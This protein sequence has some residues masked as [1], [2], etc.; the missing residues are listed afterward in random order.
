MISQPCGL[1]ILQVGVQIPVCRPGPPKE[2]R[3]FLLE[4]QHRSTLTNHPLQAKDLNPRASMK[5]SYSPMCRDDSDTS[6]GRS[7]DETREYIEIPE[8][9][10]LA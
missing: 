6:A 4:H 8:S 7:G 5:R 9:A 10:L 3:I 1:P 2:Y